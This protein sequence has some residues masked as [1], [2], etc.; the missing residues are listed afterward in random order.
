MPE[1]AGDEL[2]VQIKHKIP[3]QPIIMIT[4]YAEEFTRCGQSADALL[5]KPFSFADLRQA[6]ARLLST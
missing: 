5:S 3:S 6:I 4:A 1:M 2:V